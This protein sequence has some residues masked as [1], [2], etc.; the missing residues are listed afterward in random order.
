MTRAVQRAALAALALGAVA[1]HPSRGAPADETDD[2][3]ASNALTAYALVFYPR[4]PKALDE[5]ARRNAAERHAEL[6]RRFRSEDDCVELAG[7]MATGHYF[8]NSARWW[9]DPG[10]DPLLPGTRY[11]CERECCPGADWLCGVIGAGKSPARKPS[12]VSGGGGV[13]KPPVTPSTVSGRP[14]PPAVPPPPGTFEACAATCTVACVHEPDGSWRCRRDHSGSP[15]GAEVTWADAFKTVAAAVVAIGGAGTVIAGL[16]SWFGKLWADRLMEG[17]RARHDAEL[18]RLRADYTRERDQLRNELDI[19][20]ERF[21]T[22]HHEKL[23]TYRL[24]SDIVTDLLAA[25]DRFAAGRLPP[26]EAARIRDDF[27]RLRLRAYAYLAMLAPQ[28]VM[29][30][31]DA[32]TDYLLAVVNGEQAF[33]WKAMRGLALALLN[34]IRE[35]VGLDK[36]PVV[37]RGIR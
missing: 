1:C 26:D 23:A 27:N 22:A 21:L 32:L 29:D 34:R 24:G 30:A 17:Y 4:M 28:T 9:M 13:G 5:A 15:A 16:S 31:F 25:F 18:E 3:C 2:P 33:D 19:Y 35:D 14:T 10:G 7:R 8:D 37:Y 20:R 11:A 6:F 12:A 36:E